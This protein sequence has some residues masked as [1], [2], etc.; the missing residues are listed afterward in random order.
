MRNLTLVIIT[1]AIVSVFDV[2]IYGGHFFEQAWQE[3]T[4]QRNKI[5]QEVRYWIKSDGR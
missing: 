2:Y 1:I 3:V 5:G 4:Q